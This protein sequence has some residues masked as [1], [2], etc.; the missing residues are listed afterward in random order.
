MKFDFK[1][2]KRIRSA[3]IIGFLALGLSSMAMAGNYSSSVTLPTAHSKGYLYTANIPVSGRPPA[4]G[5]VTDVSW[6]WN[7]IGWPRALEV[8]L[9]TGKSNCIDVSRQRS[10]STRHFIGN[11]AQQKF[12][13]ALRI[14]Q[15]GHVPLAGQQGRI[16]VNW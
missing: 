12:Y 5:R 8:Q 13:F 15:S 7:V 4:G 6:T 16:T 3:S 11:P 2:S 9:C 14:G 1:K 10:G